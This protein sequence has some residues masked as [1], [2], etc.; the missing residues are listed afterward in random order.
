MSTAH[1]NEPRNVG[2]SED[3][4]EYYQDR[5]NSW[6]NKDSNK[7]FAGKR[8]KDLFIFAM[9]LGKNRNQKSEFKAK[10]KQNNV[11]V[12]AMNERQKWALLSIGIS[13][14]EGLMCLKDE[15]QIYELAEK[16]AKEGMDILKSHIDMW[17]PSYPKYLESELKEVLGIKS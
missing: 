2:Y 16:Y 9:A 7:I 10:E 15:K 1:K 13:E 3:H 11:S 17:G 5:E 14:S 4:A 8:Q 12:E 6:I